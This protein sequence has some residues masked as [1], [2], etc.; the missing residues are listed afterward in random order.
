MPFIPEGLSRLLP[1]LFPVLLQTDLA[2]P[3]LFP[4]DSFPPVLVG[5]ARL[6]M[7]GVSGICQEGPKVS[8][9]CSANLLLTSRFLKYLIREE[10]ASKENQNACVGSQ[11]GAWHPTI[12]P[13][14][15]SWLKQV[16]GSQPIR[17]S[18]TP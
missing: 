6:S 8:V 7:S 11:A 3:T 1:R 14:G 17:A 9:A 16:M 5:C 10:T 15:Q 13:S 2:H 4:G 12:G 18:G